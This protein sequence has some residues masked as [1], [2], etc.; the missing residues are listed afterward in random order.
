LT[1]SARAQALNMVWASMM[2]LQVTTDPYLSVMILQ[3]A[4]KAYGNEMVQTLTA[5]L[6][7]AN[8]ASQADIKLVKGHLTFGL[9]N[10]LD[11]WIREIN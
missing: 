7:L 11:C 9:F 4:V 2:A 8:E 3:D 10:K 1:D 6:I 5:E